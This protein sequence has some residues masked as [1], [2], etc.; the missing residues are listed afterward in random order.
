MTT[1]E[2][3][4]Q[5][6]GELFPDCAT[7]D[8]LQLRTMTDDEWETYCDRIRARLAEES[9]RRRAEQLERNR[10]AFARDQEARRSDQYDAERNGQS[11]K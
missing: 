3:I 1:D 7:A 6:R 2:V 9:R 11:K 10:A 8:A 5:V 4:A